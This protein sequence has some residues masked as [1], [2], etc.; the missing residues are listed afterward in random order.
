MNCRLA[1][2]TATRAFGQALACVLGQT[3]HGLVI[4]LVGELGA[5]KTEL[6]RATIQALG[7]EGPV[8]SPSY[9]L[10]EPYELSRRTARH[11]DLYRLG[12]PEEIEYLGIR[13][14]EA[15]DLLFIE[16]A[17]RG[18]GYLPSIDIEFT[19]TY[20]QTAR[21]LGAKTNTTRG[22]AVLERLA[23]SRHRP[24]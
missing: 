3:P 22:A 10:I 18:T 13:D 8:A 24:G 16:W 11:M 23:P 20:E 1:D 7:H 14:I 5:G 9:T 4:S 17:E 6:V 15:D 2:A 19:L 12:D 21:R